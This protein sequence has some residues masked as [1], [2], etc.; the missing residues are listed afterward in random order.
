MF[1][2]ARSTQENQ[3]KTE[4]RVRRN[5]RSTTPSFRYKEQMHPIRVGSLQTAR[6][7]MSV[8]S[9]PRQVDLSCLCRQ[10]LVVSVPNADGRKHGRRLIWLLC[11]GWYRMTKVRR[12]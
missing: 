1:D 3:T 5:E 12:G 2:S 8:M 7:L 6:A 4:N 10:Y 11:A 9:R